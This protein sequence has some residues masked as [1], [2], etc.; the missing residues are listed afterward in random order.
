MQRYGASAGK[1]A[2]FLRYPQWAHAP[3]S[4]VCLANIQIYKSCDNQVITSESDTAVIQ[5]HP[6]QTVL[7]PVR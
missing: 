2:G 4:L 6:L 1:F 7:F 5:N 3:V